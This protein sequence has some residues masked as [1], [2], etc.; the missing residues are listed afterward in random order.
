M[1]DS[2]FKGFVI[3]RAWVTNP[4]TGKRLYARDYGKRAWPIYIPVGKKKKQSCQDHTPGHQGRSL[5]AKEKLYFGRAFLFF[6][7][8]GD[9]LYGRR[10]PE[11]KT[12]CD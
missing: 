4:K 7:G 11:N 12:T 8:K 3:F 10:Q 5:L 6:H 9:A 1:A 2:K